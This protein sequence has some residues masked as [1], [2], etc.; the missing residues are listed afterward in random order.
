MKDKLTVAGVLLALV[1]GVIGLFTGD[2]TNPIIERKETVKEVGAIPGDRLYTESF[3]VNGVV[4]SYRAVNF[5]N[6]TNTVC[7]LKAP[8]ATST[9]AYASASFTTSSTT[10][11][12]VV[13]TK[14]STAFATTTAISGVE[15]LVLN[16]QGTVYAS[17]TLNGANAA[18]ITFAP[19]TFLN[20]SMVTTD[21]TKNGTMS[22]TGGC[23]AQFVRV[24][25]SR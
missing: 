9:L 7:S 18:S 24:L 15:Q 14:A 16:A 17:T 11:S 5:L 12:Q 21:N 3:G 8:D 13:L 2:V 6:A 4:T 22:P 10:A 23:V 19:N 1:L 25:P 20:V